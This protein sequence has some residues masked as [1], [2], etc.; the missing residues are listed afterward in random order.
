M[1]KTDVDFDVWFGVLQ[2]NVLDNSGVDFKD[3][4]SVR[5]DYDRGRDVHDVMAEISAEYD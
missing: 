5:D 2:C 1:T 4:D 3:S